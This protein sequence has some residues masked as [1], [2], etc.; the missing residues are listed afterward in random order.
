MKRFIDALEKASS[1]AALHMQRDL[2]RQARDHGWSSDVIKNTFVE[3]DGESYKVKVPSS[4]A[5]QAFIHE[6]GSP[7]S[8]PTAAIRKYENSKGFQKAFSKSMSQRGK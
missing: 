1:D 8:R 4:H 5:D 2:R 3:Y 7:T 6:F